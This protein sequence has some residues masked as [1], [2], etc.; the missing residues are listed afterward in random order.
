[1]PREQ[2][3]T[4]STGQDPEENLP[5]DCLADGGMDTENSEKPCE[6]PDEA[7]RVLDRLLEA[8]RT[9]FDVT[10]DYEYA[11]Q[12]FE[13]YAEFHS[14][15]EKYVLVKKAKLW[16]VD[17][18]EYIF[19]KQVDVLSDALLDELL[20]FMKTQ[21]VGKVD[22][23]PNHMKSYVSLVIIAKQLA[24]G[25][26]KRVTRSKFHKTYMFGL[27]GWA[28]LRLCAV[29]LTSRRVLTNAEGK[30]MRHALEENSGFAARGNKRE[31]RR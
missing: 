6:Q 9:W 31:A 18:A 26:D 20:E 25:V 30:A 22:P 29:D 2:R 5:G 21:A 14:H 16:E 3:E 27:R 10:R 13:G 8:H 23:A 1:M 4:V 12:S 17:A 24:P 19:F 15:G 28:E 11:G 7:N